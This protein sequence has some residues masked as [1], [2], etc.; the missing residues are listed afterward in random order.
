MN[1]WYGVDLDGTLAVYDH[2]RGPMIGGPVPLMVEFVKGLMAGGK[3]VRIFTARVCSIHPFSI[4]LQARM[5]IE[6]W[7]DMHLGRVLPVTSEKDPQMICLYDDRCVQVLTNTGILVTTEKLE[8]IIRYV[9]GMLTMD[10][11]GNIKEF[12][13]EL[14]RILERNTA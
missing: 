4:R 8:A 6:S 3:D 5:A 7:R 11:Q 9:R 2:W 1:G 12:G 14:M 13:I 10:T